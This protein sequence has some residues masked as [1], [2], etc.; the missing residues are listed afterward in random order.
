MEANIICDIPLSSFRVADK[1]SRWPT[2]VGNFTV[3]SVY[4]LEMARNSRV[5][6]EMST[7]LATN[8]IWK[9]LWS[10]KVPGS[11]KDSI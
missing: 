7:K 10:M 1:R 9:S 3:K 8:G 4:Y 6:G 11:V 2:N 5:K